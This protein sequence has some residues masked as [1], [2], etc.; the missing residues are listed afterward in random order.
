MT[1]TYKSIQ[2]K[3]KSYSDNNEQHGS[4]ALTDAQHELKWVKT[5]MK[6][7]KPLHIIYNNL[8]ANNHS[9]TLTKRT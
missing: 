6:R 4:A 2:Y 5:I 9:F 8:Q 1:Y 7:Q 3:N